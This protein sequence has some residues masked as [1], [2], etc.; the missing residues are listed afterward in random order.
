[1]HPY[2]YVNTLKIPFVQDSFNKLLAKRI[3]INTPPNNKI[4][5]N[6]L[7]IDK[8]KENLN[9]LLFDNNWVIN[10]L[11]NKYDKVPTIDPIM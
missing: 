8:K 11:S 2:I 1:M 4:Q 7:H 5:I 3:P 9:D 10:S 6:V